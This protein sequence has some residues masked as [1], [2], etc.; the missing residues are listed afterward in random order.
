MQRE[1]AKKLI[2]DTLEKPFD[3]GQ[4]KLFI[5]N[6]LNRLEDAP[7][8]YRGE[9][10]FKDYRDSVKSLERIGKYE[11][12][13]GKKLDVL[14]VSLLKAPSLERARSK[15]RNF[16]AKYLKGS[17]GN[18]LKDGALVAF[19]SPDERDWRFSF[20]KMEYKFD[21][22]KKG[23]P[24]VVEEF[25]PARRYSFLVGE[26]E[27]SHTA[28][29]KLLPT[30]EETDSNPTF[31]D[32]QEAFNI[33]KVTKEFFEQYRQLFHEIKEALDKLAKT[34]KTIKQDFEE[35]GVDT[36]D[37]AK[38]LLGQIVFLYFLQKKGWFGVAR[39]EAWGTGPKNF[40]RLLFEGRMSQYD[41]F[42]ND[43]LEPLFYEVLAVDRNANGDY[44]S[45]FKCKIP[46]LNGGLFDPLNNYD[47]VHTDIL[48]PEELFSNKKKTKHGDIGT[49]ILDVFDRYNFTVKEDE[50][51]EKEVAVDPEMLGKVFENLLEV[52]D[53]K[54]KGTYYT[55]RE[56]V[57]YMCQESLIN[58]L[59]TELNERVKRE[60]IE[61]L[62]KHGEA[63]L[64]NDTL[65][66]EQG[67]ETSRYKYKL[68]KSIRAYNQLIDD[69]LADIKVC[70]P[71]VGSGAFLVGMMNEIVKTRSVLAR[72]NKPGEE[73]N[74]YDFKRDAIQGSLYGVDIDL[75]AVEIAKLRLWLSLIVDEE[76]YKHIKPLPNLD[77][78]IMQGNSLLEEYEGIKLIDER[79]FE[80]HEEKEQL[81]KRLRDQQTAFQQEYFD[82]HSNNRLSRTKK[83]EIEK[84][85]KKIDK[86]IK[87][88][89]QPEINDQDR[90]DIFGQT[91]AQSK[92]GKLLELHS[93]FFDTHNKSAKDRLH[94]EIETLTWEL[95]EATLR[96]EGKGDK[97]DEVQRFQRTNSSPFFLWRLNYAEIF[98]ERGG[99]DVVMANPPYG[100]DI[101][102]LV[103]T[104]RS[105]YP[106]VITHYADIFKLFFALGLSK[107]LRQNGHLVYIT[108]NTYLSQPR[109]RDLRNF[110]LSHGIL[111]I[112]N[113]GMGV[114]PE[115][116]VPV[117][118]T[119]AGRTPSETGQYYFADLKYRVTEVSALSNLSFSTIPLPDAIT[120]KDNSLYPSVVL[121]TD[122]KYFEDIF[123][124][125]DGGIQ[126][127]RSG[128][129]LKNKGGNDLY[130]RIFDKSSNGRF[131]NAVD[132][133]YGKLID[134]YWISDQSNECFNLD[135]KAVLKPDESV[136]FSREAFAEN[137]KLLWR[138]TAS[139][140]R[141]TIDTKGRWFR[142]TI[143]CAWIKPA[144]KG[145]VDLK[146][147]L[148]V[149]N[150]SYVRYKYNQ[151]VQESGRVFPQI[152]IGKVKKLPF[153]I[154]S[155][156]QQ[157]H[158]ASIVDKIL[159]ITCKP[160]F[161]KVPALKSEVDEL[162]QAVDGIIYEIY[163]ISPEEIALISRSLEE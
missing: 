49:G 54:S 96:Q 137:N 135:Y 143:Q 131:A 114:F 83:S 68:P 163:S 145:E 56:I 119:I 142:N 136:S 32:I 44:Y 84:N 86:Q 76:D 10:I 75:G 102:S 20:V 92:A 50:P 71:A 14:I 111:K 95:I 139:Y 128:I 148:A 24:K 70:D 104:Y 134:R 38:K 161:V 162:S 66:S 159:Q 91:E 45:P 65:V 112:L 146:Y 46:F 17:R 78:K 52:K 108:P 73:P 28:Q 152:K 37:F 99:F 154:A 157:K 120:S 4:F 101:D 89:D 23:T 36:V 100:A 31:A 33:E 59:A 118:V 26:H 29:S 85:L 103:G 12:S 77:Y 147:A 30:L 57:H 69:K 5:K 151:L 155:K 106:G 40:L 90:F 129:G 115:V 35:K 6:L 63:A 132:T 64:E 42:F 3:K 18:E 7:F 13:D 124:I 121:K 150:S 55:P 133:W 53:R 15:Q 67:E 51:L 87:A 21:T 107:I 22:T 109:H 110:L 82:L 130:D 41:N 72:L 123:E 16:V 97:L 58:H 27:G 88:L 1:A 141:A 43:I 80:K 126:Y 160:A 60:D 19:V 25:T 122:E 9:Y 144:Y 149:F 116:V 48:L 138:Q 8:I 2:R 113:L 94:K 127:H 98:R 117:C 62:I 74:I 79:F 93:C 39:N 61:I 125:K 11:D 140:L 153:R 156:E 158:I 47:W 34:D 105:R 81:L